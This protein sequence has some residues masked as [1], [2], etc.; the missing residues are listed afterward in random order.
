M[1]DVFCSRGKRR[2]GRRRGSAGELVDTRDLGGVWGE[3]GRLP[4][5]SALKYSV[6]LFEER[7]GDG[8]LVDLF[9]SSWAS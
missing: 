2:T 1:V 7:E 9:K 8:V 5:S 6:E 3:A 4:L